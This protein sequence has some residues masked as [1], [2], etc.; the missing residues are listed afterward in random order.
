MLCAVLVLAGCA[1][2]QPP[3]ALLT[4]TE[5]A[6]ARAEE[7]GAKQDAPLELRS[8]QKKLEEARMAVKNK[9]MDKA[10][11]LVEEA[12]IDAE[13]AD[14]AARSS[15]ARKAVVQ[16]RASIEAMRQEMAGQQK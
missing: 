5:E 3:T 8:A 10:K 4:R 9:D 14:V 2:S 12:L 11:R 15:K 13:V 16:I 6:I 7:N 1:A